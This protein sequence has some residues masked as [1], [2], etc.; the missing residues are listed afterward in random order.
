MDLLVIAG[1]LGAGKTTMLMAL[2]RRLVDRGRR[3]AIIENEVGKVGVDDQYLASQGL[4]V[5]EI[6]GGCVCCS[7][8]PSLL[9]TLSQIRK[10]INPDL[11][12]LEPSGV[13]GPGMLRQSIEGYDGLGRIVVLSIFDAERYAMLAHVARPLIEGS[14]SAA[15]LVVINKVDLVKPERL[16]E[17]IAEVELRRADVPV[18]TLSAKTDPQAGQIL[19]ALGLEASEQGSPAPA[20]APARRPGPAR[21]HGKRHDAKQEDGHGHTHG[22]NA[23][24]KHEH[25]HGVAGESHRHAGDPIAEAR[26]VGL[27][28]DP[29]VEAQSLGVQV[30]AVLQRVA[31]AI[32]TTPDAVVGHVKCALRTDT[33]QLLLVRTTSA[34][35]PP[36][37]VGHVAAPTRGVTATLNAIAYNLD[38]A[39]LVRLAD[40]AAAEL[41]SLGKPATE[42]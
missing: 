33:G 7:L 2:A 16:R 39:S 18:L 14:I 35:H 36:D 21:D 29:P 12:V 27:R 24:H 37:I 15:D 4:K 1:F 30:A 9:T 22:P 38:R 5:R 26:Q 20:A 17:L 34:E 3:I 41:A 8:G 13:A 25:E 42:P 6:F 31:R 28:F 10:E 40:T 19:R 32:G 11:V 23:G